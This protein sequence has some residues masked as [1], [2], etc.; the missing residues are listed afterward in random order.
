M[1]PLIFA[2]ALAIGLTSAPSAEAQLLR[3]I[4]NGNSQVTRQ[5]TRVVTPMRSFCPGGVCPT[6][7]RS[8]VHWSYQPQ[9][10][11][12]IAPTVNIA[13]VI[14]QPIRM[15]VAKPT[16]SETFGL[17]GI[18]MPRH[19]LGQFG[20]DVESEPAT[21]ADDQTF[22]LGL[23]VKVEATPSHILGQFD[24]SEV[25]EEGSF[26]SALIKGITAARKSGSI[27][28]LQAL[29]L[30]VA[31]FSPAFVERAQELA[32]VQITFSGQSS[33]AVPVNNDGS[34][35]VEG[36]NWDGLIKFMEAFIPLLITLLK[37]FGI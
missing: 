28:L 13:P 4:F 7:Q 6:V 19:I 31:C 35:N 30:R 16:S 22:G 3:R 37:A 24:A 12:V 36:I 32:V 11:R 26:K 14:V 25:A 15:P 17:S 1:K 8:S 2:L 10:M 34:I 27:T 33:D 29:R 21:V 20:G 5:T 23:G 9:T 18:V